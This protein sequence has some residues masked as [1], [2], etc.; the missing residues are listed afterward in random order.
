M[1]LYESRNKAKTRAMRPY[2]SHNKVETHCMRLS[3]LGNY[4]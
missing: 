1:R 2:Q 3:N 4:K